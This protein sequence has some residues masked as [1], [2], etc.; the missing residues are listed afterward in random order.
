M[1]NGEYVIFIRMDPQLF[2]LAFWLIFYHY[3]F[4]MQTQLNRKTANLDL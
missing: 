4:R 3:N 1:N 2:L